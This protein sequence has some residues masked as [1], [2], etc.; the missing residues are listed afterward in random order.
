VSRDLDTPDAAGLTRRE[1]LD[2]LRAYCERRIAQCRRDEATLGALAPA[3][4]ESVAERRAYMHVCSIMAWPVPP[5]DEA[6]L[7]T[8]GSN[9]RSRWAGRRGR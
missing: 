8:R 4:Y 2:E 7:R 9:P 6:D 1:R 5:R 3:T